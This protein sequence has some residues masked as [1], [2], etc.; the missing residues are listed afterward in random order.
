LQ[1]GFQFAPDLLASAQA[2]F[3][4][5]LV[6]LLDCEGRCL[7]AEAIVAP[8]Q[9][10]EVL[11]LRDLA[12]NV[13]IHA[14]ALP[15]EI[16]GREQALLLGI[17]LV[18]GSTGNPPHVFLQGSLAGLAQSAALQER[19]A[20]VAA[21]QGDDIGSEF[22][23]NIL[24]LGCVPES[25]PHE[26][27]ARLLARSD[28]EFRYFSFADLWP[29]FDIDVDLMSTLVSRAALRGF[30]RRLMGF[31]SASPEHLYRNFLEGVG[32]VHQRPEQIEV[33]LPRS[34]LSLVLQLSGLAKQ[35]YTVPWLERREGLETREGLEGREVCL[36]PPRE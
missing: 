7:V 30:A 36:L 26:K 13:W 6:A 5:N 19:V 31:Q 21:F 12:R 20:S 28:A 25:T 11:L 33:E 4:A 34:P 32:K 8:G 15:H 35:I 22:A 27:I 9:Q 24:R 14:S 3:A 1:D 18:R 23:E 16:E 2:L 10:C 17:D 29:G